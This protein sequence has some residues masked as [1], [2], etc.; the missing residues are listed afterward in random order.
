MAKDNA[1]FQLITNNDGTYL[2]L[3][4]AKGLGKIF[5]FSELDEYLTKR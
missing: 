3:I 5:L 1:I 2:Q 4:P